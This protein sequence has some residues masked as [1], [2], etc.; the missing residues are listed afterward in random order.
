MACNYRATDVLADTNGLAGHVRKAAQKWC[1]GMTRDHRKNKDVYSFTDGSS[2]TV[3]GHKVYIDLPPL[4]P[5]QMAALKQ[6]QRDL[7]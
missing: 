3:V 7:K 5:Y 4:R 2:L 1:A 6:A